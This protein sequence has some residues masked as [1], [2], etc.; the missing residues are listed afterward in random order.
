VLLSVC[1]LTA[2][3]GTPENN[4]VVQKGNSLEEG[5]KQTAPSTDQTV[6]E[7]DTEERWEYQKAY[8][9]GNRLNVDA[10]IINKNKAD[11]PVISVCEKPFE[12]GQ[13]LKSIVDVF[14]PG[15]KVLEN[16]GF[17]KQHL[18]Q[19][20]L[21]VKELIFRVENDMPL[22]QGTTEI[23]PDNQKENFLQQ[24]NDA[25]EYY[26]QEL[27]TAPD[28]SEVDE[29]SFEFREEGYSFQ[30]N[31]QAVIDDRVVYFD[32]VNWDKP[33]SDFYLRDAKYESD[34]QIASF[35]SPSSLSDDDTFL[36]EKETIDA[37]LREMGIDYMALDSVSKNK[38]GYCFYYTREANDFQETYAK[39]YLGEV[40]TEGEVAMDL[41]ESEHFEIETRDGQ[42]VKANWHNPT[43]VIK[44]DNSNVR[45]LPWEQI[46]EIY[47][48]QMDYMLSPDSESAGE[49]DGMIFLKDTEIHINKIE[50]GLTKVLMKDSGGD[51]KLIP[52]W[53]FMGYDTHYV[54]EGPE[55]GSDIC[56]LTINAI[57]GTVIDRGLMY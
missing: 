31:M 27:E 40:Q 1:F 22:Y 51:Y 52:A 2:C 16:V 39:T 6:G 19:E 50:L 25:I 5:I 7:N 57:D 46:Q 24:L 21:E 23:I 29:A 20:I 36:K 8:D 41:F 14:C 45:V 34:E 9:S 15:A 11:I 56:F 43:E 28:I 47:K 4:A 3:Q 10:V 42:V 38:H 12:G 17:T 55:H 26:E 33:G 18:D 44:E 37:I 53:S 32:F 48:K 35:K 49:S 13:Q 30:S 54:Q